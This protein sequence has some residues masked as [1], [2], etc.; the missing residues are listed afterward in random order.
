[1]DFL[2]IGKEQPAQ[3]L[4]SP[5]PLRNRKPCSRRKVAVFI[6]G[7]PVR[8]AGF[9]LKKPTSGYMKKPPFQLITFTVFF[10]KS[11]IVKEKS[12]LLINYFRLQILTNAESQS[13]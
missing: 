11:M 5:K 10:L 4:P 7:V 8:E 3:L 2:A 9:R 12:L 1:V 13:S 6:G